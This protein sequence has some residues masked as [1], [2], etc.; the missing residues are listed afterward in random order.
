MWLYVYLFKYETPLSLAIFFGKY[1]SM[2][3]QK[4]KYNLGPQDKESEFNQKP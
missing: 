2:T 4:T 3:A 1:W